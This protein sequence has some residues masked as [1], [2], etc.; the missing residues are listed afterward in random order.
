MKFF[1][2]SLFLL[3]IS[4]VV[5]LNSTKAYA[6]LNN[7]D[8]FVGFFH[9]K[10]TP[11]LK[12]IDKSFT[13]VFK[14]Y[15]DS[16]K[17]YFVLAYT[18]LK[19]PP[20]FNFN[21]K[22]NLA[23]IKRL[24]IKYHSNYIIT[25]SIARFGS[26]YEIHAMLIE[27]A[28][29]YNSKT[30]KY[31]GAGK[32][33]LEKSIYTLS[34]K[35]SSLI[36]SRLKAEKIKKHVPVSKKIYSIR[37]K[38]NI[39]TGASFIASKIK[40]KKGGYYSIKK[41][42]ESV[43]D[44]YKTGYFKNIMVNARAVPEGLAVTF[45]VSERPYIKYIKYSGNA[46]V[47][48]KKIKKVINLK[49]NS[50]YSSYGLDKALKILKFIYSAEGYYNAKIKVK[51]TTF[52]GNYIG[53]HFLINENSPVMV[54]KVEFE[55]NSSFPSAKLQSVMGIKTVNLLT[56]ITGAGKF[57]KA[58]LNNQIIKLLG[59]YYNHGYI[60]V[61]VRKP[62]FIFSKNKKYVTIIIKIV[63]GPQY[64][65]S[66]VDLEI[67][68]VKKDSGEYISVKKLI[69]TKVGDIFNRQ[70]IEK[71]IL[72][73]TKFYTNKGYA[74]ANV[75]PSIKIRQKTNSVLI[76]LIVHK[77]KIAK[78]GKITI[79]GNDVT[80]SYVILRALALYPGEEYNPK[81]IK[82]SRQNLKNL[83][84][85]KHVAITTEKVPGESILDV[86]VHVK[87]QNTGKFTIGGGYSSATAF[88]AISSIS[89]S[90]LFGTGISASL[91]AQ[92]GGPYQS[93]SFN[94]L[95]PYLTYI[96]AKPLS[97][98]LSLYDTFNGLYYEFAYRSVGGSIT[99]GYPLYKNVLTEYFRYLLEEDT[100][101][102]IPGLLNILPQG[103]LITSEAS[104]TTV[105]NTLNNPMV[106]TAG[107]LDSFRVSF[108][109]PPIGGNDDFIKFVAQANHY[110]P[111]WWGT[112]FMQGAQAGYVTSTRS[113]VALPIY[114]RF[115]VGGIM[116]TYPLLGF[117]YDSVGPSQNGLLIGGTKM[118]TVQAKYSVPIL[119]K[120]GFYGFLWWNAGNAWG[121]SEPVFPL[122]LVQ[123]AGI[124]FNWYS[125][126]GPITI[127]YGKIL[128]TPINGNNPTR[129]QFSLG[130][131]FPGI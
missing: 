100:S 127:T 6:L 87:E 31:S 91:N 41:I 85:F 77:G 28:D 102:I 110:I 44:L 55:G 3:F 103:R 60:N 45:I 36:L 51:K 112:S 1:R 58:K 48:V 15:M 78:F 84:Y 73:I 116:N 27:A 13:D 4:F 123:A 23:G 88:M 56:W 21:T 81:L 97:F 92:V 47:S 89:E 117:M 72:N 19:K 50:P 125:P 67:K 14:T 108:A 68:N 105:Y 65:I 107:N 106:P 115:F 83:M 42:N 64:R 24:G 29:I 26:H 98:N 129:I 52:Q 61:R 16:K 71:E 37:V 40:I 82:I 11:A 8:V 104:L 39:R 49:V 122:D 22:M 18:L 75:E 99:L 93:Y 57:K 2:L 114:Q 20:Y 5:F 109:G 9:Q 38:G 101:V 113:S 90:N 32:K 53:I 126:F 30:V 54:E 43:K 35:V 59:F 46:S 79:T 118:F 94:I 86:K 70:Y 128:G 66:N 62:V 74:F 95:Q 96:F 121:Q 120:M 130:Q 7:K 69:I 131:S 12:N 119:K 124:G 76:K 63:Q 33:S 17:P 25:G 80:Y 10:G 111:L 34:Q